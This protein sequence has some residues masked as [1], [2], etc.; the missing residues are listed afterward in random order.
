M[1]P[2]NWLVKTARQT[3]DSVAL[4]KG[5]NPCAS[6]DVFARRAALALNDG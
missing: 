5:I 3:P 6:Y 4:V 2:A 1:N